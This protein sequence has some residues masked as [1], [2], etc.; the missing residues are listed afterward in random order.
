MSEESHLF[1]CA[2]VVLVALIA[3]VA[4]YN[5]TTQLALIRAGVFP[6]PALTVTGRI[7]TGEHPDGGR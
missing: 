4:A 1:I 6:V 7:T 3:A 2:A 5:I